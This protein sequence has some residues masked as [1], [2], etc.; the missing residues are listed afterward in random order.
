ME[1][2]F[3]VPQ[4]FGP[5][6][7]N[8]VKLA[9]PIETFLNHRWDW[10]D[11]RTFASR[12]HGG[13][14][15]IIWI[16]VHTFLWVEGDNTETD[17]NQQWNVRGEASLSFRKTE[18]RRSKAQD[19]CYPKTELLTNI[20]ARNID[21]IC[22][23]MDFW[24]KDTARQDQQIC[25]AR[26]CYMHENCPFEKSIMR[27]IEVEYQIFSLLTSLYL[28]L[29]KLKSNRTYQYCFKLLINSECSSATLPVSGRKRSG[30]PF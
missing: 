4:P 2:L 16:T 8:Q 18:E 10:L 14:G 9:E 3:T 7:H 12:D 17:F 13:M 11:F 29:L 23:L 28:R 24:T 27:I 15:T 30:P 1:H 20:Y 22:A 25:M 26:Q 5:H 6:G 19:S 21:K